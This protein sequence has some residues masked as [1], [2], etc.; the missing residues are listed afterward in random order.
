MYFSVVHWPRLGYDD[1][2][3]APASSPD[4]AASSADPLLSVAELG[5]TI[6]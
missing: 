4:P 3:H 6:R 1:E 5:N 2:T